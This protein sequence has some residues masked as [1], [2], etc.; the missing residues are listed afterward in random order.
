M[1]DMDDMYA[2]PMWD[3]VQELRNK[4]MTE[5]DIASVCAMIDRARLMNSGGSTPREIT[6]AHFPWTVPAEQV[7]NSLY[8]NM[9][10]HAEYMASG[11]HGMKPATLA[12]L[13][14]F[15]EKL[16]SENVVVEFDPNIPPQSE[17]SDNGGFAL[18]PR[19]MK[20][21]DFLIRVN[22]HTTMTEEGEMLWCFP[23]DLPEVGVIGGS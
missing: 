21:D 3:I 19:E 16:Q 11:G 10:D 4:G 17:I 23:P 8:W 9:L 5:S 1:D 2:A 18:R 13:R 12:R 20:D 14:E 22:E 15:Y 6:R 7:V